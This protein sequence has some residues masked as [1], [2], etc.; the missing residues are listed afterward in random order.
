M[1]SRPQAS[2]DSLAQISIAAV[3]TNAKYMENV[4]TA[5]VNAIPSTSYANC[6][7]RDGTAIPSGDERAKRV[8]LSKFV[9]E[10][11]EDLARFEHVQWI[12]GQLPFISPREIRLWRMQQFANY[13]WAWQLP[14]DDDLAMIFN[15]TRR[16]A[17]NLVSDF[18][19]RFRKTALFPVAIRRAYEILQGTPFRKDVE[20]KGQKAIGKVFRVPSRRYIENTNALISEFRL[21]HQGRLLRDAVRYEHD[22]QHIWVSQ[23]VLQLIADGKLRREIF[24]LYP[25]LG[26]AG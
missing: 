15:L 23:E 5:F 24:D 13:L 2:P 8:H 10:R 26:Q 25:L 6:K 1:A 11:L 7:L 14:D 18:A 3:P 19:A 21:R 12:N 16:Q 4:L 9:S 22:D 17:S 20:L